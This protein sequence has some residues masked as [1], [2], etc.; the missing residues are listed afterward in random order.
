MNADWLGVREAIGL[1][2]AGIR[3]LEAE[4]VEL[5]LARGRVLREDIRAPIDVPPWTNS[6]MDG[7]AVRA[8]DVEGASRDAPIVLRVIDDVPAGSFASYP[9]TPRT[10]ARVMTGA[11]VPEGADSVVRVEDTDGGQSLGTA[12][13]TVTVYDDRDAR[14]N[15][16][17]KGE[18]FSRGDLVLGSGTVLGPAAIGLAAA[19]GRPTV[20]V[21]KP[22]IV[23]LLTSGDELVDVDDFAQVLSGGRIVSSNTYTLAAQLAE[24]GCEVRHLGIVRDSPAVLNEALRGARGCDALVTSAGISVGEHDHIRGVLLELEAKVA[25]WRVRMRPGSPFAFG[26]VGALGGIPWFGLPGN[27]VSSMV[28]FELFVRP[29]LLRMAGRRDVFRRRLRA[30]AAEDAV[31]P[32]GLTHLLRV[33]LSGDEDRGLVA[34]LT[35]SQGSSMLGSMAAADGLLVVEEGVGGLERGKTYPVIPLDTAMLVD[36]P[37]F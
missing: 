20:R 22:P 14:R 9:L 8:V 2:M 15:L 34:R 29:A 3:P 37:G 36:D 32:P 17:R 12:S 26:K 10:A 23:A 28:T 35:G 25:F 24:A 4:D 5:S 31:L 27:P 21:A 6:G 1:V 7:F 18:E 11:P 33:R 30:R 16:R 19:M 13:A